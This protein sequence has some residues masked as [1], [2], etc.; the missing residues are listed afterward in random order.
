M[1]NVYK[2]CWDFFIYNARETCKATVINRWEKGILSSLFVCLHVWE[3]Q[4]TSLSCLPKVYKRQSPY[5]AP[6][7]SKFGKTNNISVSL[8]KGKFYWK[9]RAN[10]AFPQRSRVEQY[11]FSGN[12]IHLCLG[13]VVF[14]RWFAFASYKHWVGK[15][16]CIEKFKGNFKLGGLAL[17][18]LE[19]GKIN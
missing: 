10:S 18:A 1:K 2:L 13:E 14:S 5:W 12:R 17:Q 8:P 3:K 16:T 11:C 4:L 7:P 19:R 15:L 6:V 9:V